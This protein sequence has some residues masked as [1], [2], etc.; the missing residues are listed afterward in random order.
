VK[1]PTLK[2]PNMETL[3]GHDRTLRFFFR[4]S[5]K[6]TFFRTLG[7]TSGV[8]MKEIEAVYY[9]AL[10]RNG[11]LSRDML[12]LLLELKNRKFIKEKFFLSIK[13]N[14]AAFDPPQP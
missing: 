13:C 14:F 10:Y 7:S 4:D 1:H 8:K 9:F 11:Q 3:G 6:E 5:V 12:M 2:K